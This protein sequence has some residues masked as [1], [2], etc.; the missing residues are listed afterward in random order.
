MKKIGLSIALATQLFFSSAAQQLSQQQKDSLYTTINNS[1]IGDSL[2]SNLSL[3][4]VRT[5]LLD[6]MNAERSQKN[7]EFGYSQYNPFSLDSTLTEVA[8]RY[9]THMDST[10]HFDHIDEK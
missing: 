7:T 10:K 3:T 4:Q 1:S 9:A 8:Q 6:A 2:I 5:G